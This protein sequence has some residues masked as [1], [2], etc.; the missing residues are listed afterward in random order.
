[1]ADDAIQYAGEHPELPAWAIE[2]MLVAAIRIPAVRAELTLVLRPEHFDR[3]GEAGLSLLVDVLHEMHATRPNC[4]LPRREL[5]DRVGDRIDRPETAISLE[6][7]EGLLLDRKE[8]RQRGVHAGLI[9]RAYTDE[10]EGTTPEIAIAHMRRLLAERELGDTIRQAATRAGQ[11]ALRD[12]SGLI[13]QLER[14]QQRIESVHAEDVFTTVEWDPEVYRPVITHPTQFPAIDE[15]LGGGV[16]APEIYGL[17]GGTG[18]GKSTLVMQLAAGAA[19]TFQAIAKPGEEPAQVFVF[20]YEDDRQRM[21]IRAVGYAAKI[22]KDRLLTMR[23]PATDLTRAPNLLPYEQDLAARGEIP[24]GVGE[25]ER[26]NAAQTL[27]KRNLRFID[28]SG[29]NAGDGGPAEIAALLRRGI[30]AHGWT[31]GFVLIDS[32]DNMAERYLGAHGKDVKDYV[33]TTIIAF[34]SQLRAKVGSAFSVPVLV[35]N[36][37]SG[38]ANQRTPT[39]K[40]DHTNAGEA[41]GWAKPLDHHFVFGALTQDGVAQLVCT[42]SR[43]TGDSINARPRLIRLRGEFARWDVVDDEY[44]VYGSEIV[45]R[46]V[47]AEIANLPQPTGSAGVTYGQDALEF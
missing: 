32:I 43:R 4:A 34:V 37:L 14:S 25:F 33:R 17:L 29:G 38:E 20:S 24:H 41:K 7:A 2:T 16:A 27:L 30:T 21:F 13:A 23:D 3:P 19:L 5:C 8:A 31:P 18:R 9:Y 28:C 39:A 6:E 12:Y 40:L 22:A 11:G 36:Q 45:P 15:M 1:M 10:F 47:A 46:H 35:T 42:K 44:M 26:F